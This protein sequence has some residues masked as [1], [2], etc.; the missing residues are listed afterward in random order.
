M[1]NNSVLRISLCQM[2]SMVGAIELNTNKIL[3]IYNSIDADLVIFPELSITGYNCQ[4]MFI[5]SGFRDTATCYTEKLISHTNNKGIIFG[6]I[7]NNGANIYNSIVVAQNRQ[8]L[9]QHNKHVF[10]ENIQEK[11]YFSTGNSAFTHFEF[12]GYKINLLMY[13]DLFNVNFE[14]ISD[15]DL[16]VVVSASNFSTTKHTGRNKTIIENISSNIVY[17]NTIGAQ[18]AMVFDGGSFAINRKKNYISAPIKWQEKI[19]NIKMH[20]GEMQMVD[21][22]NG[23]HRYES[24]N[25]SRP[26]VSDIKLSAS[27]LD[28]VYHAMMLGMKEYAS[29]AGFKRFIL[30]LSGGIDSAVVAVLAADVFSPK[31]LLCVMLPSE[32]T[33]RDS[34]DDAIQLARTI[35]CEYAIIP[36]VEVKTATNNALQNTCGILNCDEVTNENIQPRIRATLLMAIANKQN[37]LLLCTSNKSESAVGYTTL[38]GDMTGAFAPIADLYKTQVY[39]IIKW[40]NLNIPSNSYNF[41]VMQQT[42]IVPQSIIDKEPSAEL[43]PNQK[44]SDTLLSYDLLDEILYCIIELQMLPD[45]I[46]ISLSIGKDDVMKIWRLISKSEFKRHQSVCGPKIGSTTFNID[47]KYPI[48]SFWQ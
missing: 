22:D 1:Q 23:I 14:L 16:V 39:D 44:D 43:K 8:I 46:S 15:C 19:I 29:Y 41:N 24:T 40:R 45:D 18:D 48:S 36:I 25:F 13:D 34:T 21:V 27:Q 20:A 5:N 30:G 31:N 3:E 12:M 33:S 37:R 38:Y 32:F 42:M 47:R 17:L 10:S 4:D 6:C 2:N 28:D 26:K 9:S 11:R 35:G 7:A